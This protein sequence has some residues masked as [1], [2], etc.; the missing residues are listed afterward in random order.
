MQQTI[1]QKRS[2]KKPLFIVLSIFAGIL[3]VIGIL[4]ILMLSDPNRNM[5]PAAKSD[6]VLA[7]LGVAAISGEPARLTAE[8][9]N[10]LLA[11]KL[12]SQAPRCYINPDDTV[13]VYLPVNYKG[14]HLGV[15]SNFT[16]GYNTSQEQIFAEVHS[17][18]IG[19]LPVQPALALNLLKGN[20]P[21]GV[22]VNGNV[23]RADMALFS[24]QIFGDMVGL[25]VSGLEVTGRYFVLNVTGNADKL[26]EF[27]VQTLPGYLDL[28]K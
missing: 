13:G 4:T 23:I 11:E 27:I 18:Q 16:I 26:K 10:G 20:L 19:R 5:A 6:T 3:I 22:T 8:E 15:I 7:K 25:Q 24:T 14:I 9:L 1:V 12:P 21:E 28:L 17:V 2:G